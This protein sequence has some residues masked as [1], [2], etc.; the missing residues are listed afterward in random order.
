LEDVLLSAYKLQF[1]DMT[2]K[3]SRVHVS[4]AYT[5]HFKNHFKHHVLKELR[6]RP[7]SFKT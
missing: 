3:G 6:V 5:E 2:S 4:K 1:M 7:G